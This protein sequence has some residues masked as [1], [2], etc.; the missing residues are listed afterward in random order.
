VITSPLTASGTLTQPFSYTVTATY[1]LT[2]DA[3]GLPDGL[4]FDAD[5]GVISGT[6]TTVGTTNVTLSAANT[7]GATT[8]AQL[9]ITI[10]KAT[11]DTLSVVA[12]ASKPYGSQF[13]VGSSG[14]SGGG[15]VTFFATDGCS[16]AGTTVTMTSGTVNCVLSATKDGDDTYEPTVSQSKIVIAE[17]V[18]ASVTPNP[19]T[20]VF[21]AADPT[22][23]G[24]LAGFLAADNVSATYSRTAGETVNG[25]PYTISATLAPNGVLSNYLITYH[26]ANFTITKATS[27]TAVVSSLASSVYGQSVT[28]TATVSSS[29]GT[30]TG[31]VTFTD[32]ATT[33]GSAPLNG[34]VATLSTA[35]L[36]AG[37]HTITASYGGAADYFGS[38]NSTSQSVATATT[39]STLSS[40]PNPSSPG[41]MVNF[42][43]TVISQYGGL[44]TG[45]VSFKKGQQILGTATVLANGTATLPL[46]TLGNGSTI[47][48]AI[49]EG[50]T[51]NVGSTSP[52]VTQ[53]VVPPA[54]PTTTTISSSLNP[55]IVGQ[56]VTLTVTVSSNT[57]GT[58]TGTVDFKRG[59]TVLYT[60]TLVN[61]QA[62]YTTTSLPQGT[63][64]LFAAYSGDAQYIASASPTLTQVV[65]QATTSTTLASSPNPSAGG[66]LVTMTATI[67]PSTLVTP[68]SGTVTFRRGSTVLGTAPVSG[69]QAAFTTTT[70]PAGA[71]N[72]TAIYSGDAT[73]VGSTSAAISHT[74]LTGTT[75]TTLS[76]TP[77]PS[78]FGQLVTFTAT[79]TSS[80]AGAVP[81]GTVEFAE[82]S[83][84][85]G[86][87]TLDG[88]GHAT[89]S[90]SSL[91]LKSGKT[92]THN[93]K[94][95]YV[96]DAYN[97]TSTS[98]TYAQVVNP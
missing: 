48:S 69:G 91:S 54:A 59:Q 67:T 40:S 41:Q 2:L 49:Y 64:S 18:A 61:G 82:G 87:G 50:D 84:V 62:T 45:T 88:T 29:A 24:T 20:K 85:L 66:Q 35:T 86:T 37:A 52:S 58:I 27:S 26:T 70:L 12:P 21:G 34:G 1:G 39:A 8:T 74:V 75:T 16:V 57:A 5:T 25:G 15:T 7:F 98:N 38:S 10:V 47:V 73:Y 14:G 30:P 13:V 9:A 83:T 17:R 11:Q 77:N 4:S 95:K 56:S 71:S 89:F 51:N 80:V 44:V 90:I 60:A 72:L 76:A 23:T 65:T 96:G 53:N 22:L 36:A 63:L 31:T 42:V 92:M 28:F 46:S 43:A 93:I 3:T 55:S 97:T 19:A 79:V 33:I 81:T 32:G 94:A 78:T 68:I 6:P